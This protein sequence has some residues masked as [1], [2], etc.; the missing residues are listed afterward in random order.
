VT[1]TISETISLLASGDVCV[2][3]PTFNYALAKWPEYVQALQVLHGSEHIVV[4]K[5]AATSRKT[6]TTLRLWVPYATDPTMP[7]DF[8]QVRKR[9]K[10]TYVSPYYNDKE[11]EAIV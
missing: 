11:L 6:K 9:K 5:T 10:F 3:F 8:I 2:V 1:V 4:T 7:M